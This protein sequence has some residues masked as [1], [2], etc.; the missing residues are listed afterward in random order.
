MSSSKYILLLYAVFLYWVLSVVCVYLRRN[1]TFARLTRY[2][3][4]Q[5]CESSPFSFFASSA[6]DSTQHSG[7]NSHYDVHKKHDDAHFQKHKKR[8]GGISTSLKASRK[9]RETSSLHANE[10][11]LRSEGN[12][13]QRRPLMMVD[14]AAFP[15]YKGLYAVLR[16]PLS[17]CAGRSSQVVDLFWRMLQ[18][19][20]DSVLGTCT[21]SR[22]VAFSMFYMSGLVTCFILWGAYPRTPCREA[23]ETGVRVV[24]HPYETQVAAAG[25]QHYGERVRRGVRDGSR[26]MKMQEFRFQQEWQA[27]L[28]SKPWLHD[29]PFLYLRNVTLIQEAHLMYLEDMRLC[30]A[31]LAPLGGGGGT[32]DNSIAWERL[33]LLLFAVHCFI[34]F[35]ESAAVQVYAGRRQ[36]R[37][38]LVALLAGC[39][40]YV[41]A[42]I[43]SDL[44]ALSALRQEEA[45]QQFQLVGLLPAGF[46]PASALRFSQASA[47]L[48]SPLS[49][50]PATLRGAQGNSSDVAG[51]GN[52]HSRTGGGEEE[53]WEEAFFP[54]VIRFSHFL[55]ESKK[56]VEM[57]SNRL[58][59][60][61]HFG[62]VVEV[63]AKVVRLGPWY[64]PRALLL[65]LAFLHCMVQWVQAYHHDVLASLRR[66]QAMKA[67]EKEQDE[68]KE[69]V[70][71]VWRRQE[72]KDLGEVVVRHHDKN[73][74]TRLH[75]ESLS[76]LDQS[77]SVRE[78]DLS[79]SLS[80]IS[81]SSPDH[82]V[83]S[84]YASFPTNMMSSIVKNR[85][86]G[87]F[88]STNWSV[89]AHSF[90]SYPGDGT[91]AYAEGDDKEDMEKEME[92]MA[93]AT[94]KK[95]Y[96][97][98]HDEAVWRYHFP[99]RA[100]FQ[101]ILEPH[102]LCEILMYL[103][104]WIAMIIV[105]LYSIFSP[106]TYKKY[107]QLVPWFLV[108]PPSNVLEEVPNY[109]RVSLP[110]N[111]LIAVLLM[112]FGCTFGVLCFT[113]FNLAVTAEEH[114]TFWVQLHGKRLLVKEF[115]LEHIL[116][117]DDVEAE[118][119][120]EE[121]EEELG[122]YPHLENDVGENDG[123]KEV[124]VEKDRTKAQLREAKQ[125]EKRVIRRRFHRKLYAATDPEVIPAYNLLPLVW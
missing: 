55:L 51:Y 14:A 59:S 120:Q 29:T 26:K 94:K 8:E 95:L 34:R 72:N 23:A 60:D 18:Q 105:I 2:S 100:F 43:S 80:V 54:Y 47:S 1:P 69:F 104:Q 119:E 52:G 65:F 96:E 35:L 27:M 63:L 115:V 31:H 99:F 98:V 68:L 36:D 117:S 123:K 4:R 97:A 39:T 49:L 79:P 74:I 66:G 10:N 48:H 17:L 61:L 70:Q 111:P 41:M 32:W 40:F 121:K 33:P 90:P 92:Q 12:A 103:I 37:V 50:T 64:V 6:E 56:S 67:K 83:S 20:E 110:T 101:V 107:S 11:V 118:E 78:T 87:E 46:P 91:E 102:Y 24:F 3:C 62:G 28:R 93:I 21:I 114:R 45:R 13:R 84:P 15:I 81:F 76:P 22:R 113:I 89:G 53:V 86:K 77:T 71:E 124:E 25:S 7:V 82:S 42:A 116:R 5:R 44:S 85:R 112:H 73:D 38:T 88:G 109:K 19:L 30:E 16:Y 106:A 122:V 9:S 75:L 125:L 108:A 58:D 57:A